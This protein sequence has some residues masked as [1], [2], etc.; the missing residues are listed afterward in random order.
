MEAIGAITGSALREN[1]AVFRPNN[2][3]SPTLPAMASSRDASR[4]NRPPADGNKVQQEV[5][6]KTE[7][8]ARA[9]EEYANSM[10]SNLEIRV[11]SETDT[12]VVTVIAKEDGRTIRQIPS[13]EMQDLAARM[14]QM[15]GGLLNQKV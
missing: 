13:E 14:D 5:R 3:T 1:E 6:A 11:N 10:Q 4:A 15:I 7:N 2:S 9:L 8:I 12:V